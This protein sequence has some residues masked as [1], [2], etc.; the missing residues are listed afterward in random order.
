MTSAA[1]AAGALGSALSGA[2]SSIIAFAGDDASAARVEAALVEEAGLIGLAGRST[3]V[4][5]RRD[6]ARV[7]VFEPS[8]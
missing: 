8:R 1:R 7:T 2:G 6:G 3:I 5:P 4:L